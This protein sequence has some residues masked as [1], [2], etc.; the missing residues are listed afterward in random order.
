[1]RV[2]RFRLTES[3][4]RVVLAASG[5]ALAV[6]SQPP[7]S[8]WKKIRLPDPPP[9]VHE[10]QHA[11]GAVTFRVP[12]GWAVGKVGR[13]ADAVQAVGNG[14]VLRLVYRR[15]RPGFDSLHAS[16]MTERLAGSL[17]EAPAAV[18][19]YDYV[20]GAFGQRR[21]LDSAFLVV[22]DSEVMGHRKWRQRNLTVAGEAHSLCLVA[23]APVALWKKSLEARSTLEAVLQNVKLH[24]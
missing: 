2:E 20:E 7:A 19:E 15:G 3:T 17:G 24:E 12:D 23:F 4:R 9:L 11:G 5:L 1:M 18:Y 14:L 16:C 6:V 10:H 22:Y 13:D 21:A 8:A